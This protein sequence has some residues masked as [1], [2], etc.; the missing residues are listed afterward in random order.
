MAQNRKNDNKVKASSIEEKKQE[1]VLSKKNYILLAIGF[2]IIV[3]GY[4]LLSG[5]KSDDRTIYNPEI[6]NA[7]RITVAPIVILIGFCVEIF[8]IMWKFK[9]KNVVEQNS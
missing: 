6:Y 5:G 2:A 7:M 8:A 9:K 3:I 1:F 4:F